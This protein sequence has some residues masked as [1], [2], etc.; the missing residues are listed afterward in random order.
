MKKRIVVAAACAAVLATGAAAVPASATPPE[1]SF[2]KVST[3]ASDLRGPL[4]LAVDDSGTSYVSQNFGVPPTSESPGLPSTLERIT[5]SGERT[6]VVSS[7][8]QEIG[9]VSTRRG[10]VYFAQGDQ[11]SAV[12]SLYQLNPG[13]DPIQ[14]ADLG[15]YEAKNNPDQV[16]R[17]G[18]TDLSE[19]CLAQF[20]PPPTG[21]PG[22]DTPPPAAYNGIVDTHVYASAATRRAVY[23]ADAGA[24]DI[25]RV[26]LD[27]NV[28]TVAVLPP[29]APVA[30]P[31]GLVEQFGY[32]DCA[33]GADYVFEPVPT[34]VEIGP[35]G[36]LYVT[37]LPGGPEDPS[38]GARGSVVKINPDSGEVV[39]VATGFAGAAGLAIDRRTGTIAV[40]E[41]FGG[42][43]STGQVSVV[44]PYS[45]KAVT[46]FP[47][48]SPAA[49]ELRNNRVYLT[50]NAA[51]FTDT[52]PEPGTLAVV[53]PTWKGQHW[54]R[55][56]E[57]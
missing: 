53:K 44:L 50:Y 3:I 17:Y 21:P 8:D 19:D 27:G 28:S 48:V 24:N 31:A 35:N 56:S 22:P 26:G 2:G 13:G 47:V 20:P 43:D 37:L 38:L 34:D 40:T 42:A 11:P 46:S 4:S 10:D 12:F 18:F 33:V 7:D 29:S 39:T 45:D 41:L 32:P 57:E 30:A 54:M 14:L 55:N 25:L 15:A 49:I 23:V 5:R 9:A 36:W 16:N 6:T 1:V 52:G 51:V